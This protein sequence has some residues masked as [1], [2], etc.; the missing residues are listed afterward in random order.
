[1]ELSIEVMKSSIQEVREDAKPSPFVG[2]VLVKKDGS[3][4]TAYRVLLVPAI[5]LSLDVRSAS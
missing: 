4:E 1:M 3:V 2:A 5:S